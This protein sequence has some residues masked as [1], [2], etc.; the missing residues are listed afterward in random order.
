MAPA[1]YRP[2]LKIDDEKG[3]SYTQTTDSNLTPGHSYLRATDVLAEKGDTVHSVSPADTLQTAIAQL[4]AH[5]IGAILVIEAG[6]LIG[7]LSERDVVR[8][9][10]DH[11]AAALEQPVSAVMTPE[12]QTCG[13]SDPLIRIMKR[14]TDGGFR[15]MPVADVSGNLLGMISVRDVVAY[16]LREIEH[17]ALQMKQMIVG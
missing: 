1:S 6:K 5:K 3:R 12:P 14:M 17:E 15:H 13:P 9:L 10:A 8:Q 11:A 2:A 16:R 7:I 4:K